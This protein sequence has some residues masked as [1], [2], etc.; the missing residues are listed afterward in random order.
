MPGNKLVGALL[1]RNEAAEDRY[2]RLALENALTYCDTVVCLDDGSTDDTP[3]VVQSYPRTVLMRYGATSSDSAPFWGNDE[4]TPRAF[5]WDAACRAAGE[6]GWVYIFDADH[7]L[8]GI[9]PQELRLCLRSEVVTAYT[10]P[11][12]DIWEET[13]TLL[14]SDGYW[15]AHLHPRPWLFK[16]PPPTFHSVWPKQKGIHSGHAPLNFP[17]LPGILPGAAIRHWGYA[18][19]Q[20]RNKKVQQ[21]LTLA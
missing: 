7:E 18:K 1:C 17:Y 9:T 20:H 15:Q 2:L 13:G 12:W 11:L 19:E 10:L 4:A 5:L 16:V 21:Y 8:V 14:R 6:G 3:E